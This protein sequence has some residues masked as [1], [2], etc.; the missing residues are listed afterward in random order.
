MGIVFESDT[1]SVRLVSHEIRS[2][3]QEFAVVA[4]PRVS[5]CI[6]VTSEGKVV[7]ISQYRAAVDRVLVEF[8]AG[9]LSEGEHPED[10]A[11]RELLE[12]SGFEV[13]NL[14]FVGALFTAPHFSDELVNVFM[15]NGEISVAPTPTSKEDLRQVIQVKGTELDNLIADGTIVDSKSIAAHAL[16][17][18]RGLQIGVHL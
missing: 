18:I 15:A 7:L 8:P 17:R 12:E 11:R 9:R 3:R 2:V 5:L 13:K 16:V 4:R 14:T 10:A 6:P 1:F